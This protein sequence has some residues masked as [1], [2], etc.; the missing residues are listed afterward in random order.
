MP[1]IEIPDKICPHCGGIKWK[2]EYV[3]TKNG[4]KVK[5]R[6]ALRGYERNLK[7]RIS[8]SDKVKEYN[9][10][11]CKKRRDKGYFK[12]PKERERSRLI[13]KNERDTLNNNYVYRRIFSDPEMKD[14]NRSDIPKDLIDL[15]RKQLILKRKIKN[16]GKDN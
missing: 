9:I 3:K 8:N 11:S 16:N 1:T 5:Q 14:L 6:C 4:I 7:W 12:T 15:K 10:K 13:S 2:I